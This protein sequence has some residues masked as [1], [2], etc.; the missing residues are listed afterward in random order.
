MTFLWLTRYP[1]YPPLKGGAL[2]YSRV[3]VDSLTMQ[4]AVHGLAFEPPM[5]VD[6]PD[7]EG[8]V[9][10]LIPRKMPSRVSSLLSPLPNVA[11]RNVDDGF[12]QRAI[13]LAVNAE[14]VFVDFI[15]MAWL[16]EPL[17]RA[18]AGKT[19]RPLIVMVTHNHEHDVR[20]QMARN[21]ASLSMRVA[22]S[23]DAFKAGRLERRANRAADGLTGITATDC[24]SFARDADTPA[25][26]LPPAY[27]GQVLPARVIDSSVPRVATILG[28]RD[29][30]HKIMVLER[31][32]A[33]MARLVQAGVTVS[34]AGSGDFTAFAQRFP[35]IRFEGYVDDLARYL[36]NVRVGLLTDDIGGGFKIRALTYALLRVPMIA[37][38]EAMAGM[39]LVDGVHFI[40]V[41]TLAELGEATTR[42]I[43]DFEQLNRIQ[44]AAF[45]FAIER[46]HPSS[47]G[48]RLADLVASLRLP[49]TE[50]RVP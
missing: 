10:E 40:G 19:R 38:R 45:A 39:E 9:W 20:L 2:D 16:V 46:F 14:A 5:R 43:D 35:D 37:L 36:G 22:L 12:L 42:L 30:H 18:F 24:E 44:E 7:S 34:V 25:I 21:A 33:S 47:P 28:N 26:T 31:T 50:L 6:L 27:D 15:A 17:A 23:F 11:S 4:G 49:Q 3:I 48:R 41:D 29:A 32:L 13:A 1:P 8:L